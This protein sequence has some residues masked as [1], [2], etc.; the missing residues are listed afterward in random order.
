MKRILV[1]GALGQIGSELVLKLRKL[2]GADNVIATDIRKNDTEIVHSGPFELLDVTDADAMYQI[3]KK[4]QVDTIIHLAALLSATAESKPLI[5]WNLN[6]GGLVNALEVARELKCQFFTPSSIG[7]FGP[8]T[9]KD[10][11]PQDTIQRPTTMYGVNKVAG[12]LLCDY[13]Y[14]KFGVDTRGLRFPGLISYMTPPGGGTTDYAV[15]IYYEALRSGKY[16]SYIAKGTYMDMMYMPDA[17]NA[18]VALM[19]ADPAKLKHR[20]SFNV[21]AMSFEPEEIAAEIRKHLPHFQLDYDVDPVRQAIA[22]SWPNSIDAT[23]AK[24]EW[25]FKAEYDLQKMTEDMLARLEQK[26]SPVGT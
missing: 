22:D 19:E 21:T 1:T 23:A 16:T 3:A 12:E 10:H 17:L 9:P 15:E 20:N 26:I 7:A 8:T 25:G 6:M 5:A 2:Y 14:H 24:E 4:N 18:I 13:Y 11:T